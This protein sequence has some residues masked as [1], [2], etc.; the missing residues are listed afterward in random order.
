VL[1]VFTAVSC[2][3]ATA[4]TTG[5]SDV[6]ATALLQAVSSTVRVFAVLLDDAAVYVYV[7]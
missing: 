4:A 3:V 7:R 2:G 5:S 6:N 1:L